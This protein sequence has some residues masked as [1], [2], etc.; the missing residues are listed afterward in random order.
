MK[1]ICFLF[2]C[3]KKQSLCTVEKYFLMNASFWVVETDFLANT[4]TPAGERFIFCLVETYFSMNP[5]LGFFSLMDIVTL[6]ES[7]FRLA[8]TVTAMSGDQFLKTKR[9][10]AGG[11]LASG[12]HFLSLSHIFFKESFIPISGDAFFSPKE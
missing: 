2:S 6:L 5:S 7:F 8:E 3:Q 11:I 10:L 12:N 1:I 4:E 9:I